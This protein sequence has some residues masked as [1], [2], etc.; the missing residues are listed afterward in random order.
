MTV[1]FKNQLLRKGFCQQMAKFGGARHPN[2]R[3][4]WQGL[5]SWQ[6]STQTLRTRPSG[7][8]WVHTG[9]VPGP[10]F[11]LGSRGWW[12]AGLPPGVWACDLPAELPRGRASW[13]FCCSLVAQAGEELGLRSARPVGQWL[14]SGFLKRIPLPLINFWPAAS[15]SSCVSKSS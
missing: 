4:C 8:A 10:G 7:V 1:K 15:G 13:G 9:W 2:R 5:L 12:W 11:C 14:P 6:W 3:T